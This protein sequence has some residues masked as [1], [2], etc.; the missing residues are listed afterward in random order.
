MKYLFQLARILAFCFAGEVL[1]HVIPLPIPASI[2]GL[3]LLLLGLITGIV[4]LNQVRQTGRFLS[5]LFTL[6]FVPGTVGL[7]ELWDVL[8]QIWLPILLA[9][10]P[11]TIIVFAVTGHVTQWIIRRTH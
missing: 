5:S 2:Y 11:V 1:H 7:M 4:R 6:L 8:G 9:L 10:V 3:M